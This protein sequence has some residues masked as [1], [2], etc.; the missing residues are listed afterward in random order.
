MS[1][2]R[3][4]IYDLLAIKPTDKFLTVLH[5]YID[6]INPNTTNEWWMR[7]TRESVILH[8]SLI[9]NAEKY[10]EYYQHF[11]HGELNHYF[12]KNPV[13]N[14]LVKGAGQILSWVKAKAMEQELLRASGL[15]S[16]LEDTPDD[17]PHTPEPVQY[18]T[19]TRFIPTG[20][21]PPGKR[22]RDTPEPEQ[23]A[24]SPR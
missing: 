17:K 16:A 12:E 13:P 6:K 19:K 10:A 23:A 21:R 7:P 22:I 5:H 4:S 8:F 3:Q 24:Q 14:T 18:L 20:R 11:I 1:A 2:D 9:S 15:S